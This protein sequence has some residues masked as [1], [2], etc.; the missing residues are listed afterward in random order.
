MAADDFNIQQ[1]P[2]PKMLLRAHNFR[3]DNYVTLSITHVP[4][5]VF[6]GVPRPRILRCSMFGTLL[7]RQEDFDAPD[8]E[9][10]QMLL[11][12]CF[13]KLFPDHQCNESCTD[14]TVQGGDDTPSNE[15]PV[16][17]TVQ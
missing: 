12:A 6:E 7:S 9:A 11:N 16:N 8:I 3:S 14:W 13:C 2:T 4:E 1:L 15:Q 17:Q 10:G 5:R